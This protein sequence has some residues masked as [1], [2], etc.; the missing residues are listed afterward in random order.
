M[1]YK[2]TGTYEVYF[3]TE[4]LSHFSEG[5][6]TERESEELL[7]EWL[8]DGT[9]LIEEHLVPCRE[10]SGVHLSEIA[11][12]KRYQGGTYNNKNGTYKNKSGTYTKVSE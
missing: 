3:D 4:K 2:I 5:E 10:P 1:K 6:L 11:I 12:T 8:Y 7:L 9:Q